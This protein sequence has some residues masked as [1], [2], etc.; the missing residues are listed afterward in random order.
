MTYTTLNYY[1][2]EYRGSDID[3][4]VFETLLKH[5]ERKIDSVTYYRIKK[6]GY[7]TFSDFDKEQIGLATCAQI[8]YFHE[9]GGTTTKAFESVQSVSIG[10]ASISKGSDGQSNS[11]SSSN[12]VSPSVYECLAPTGLLYA[13]IGAK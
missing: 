5:A 12:L 10:R 6:Q 9:H 11:Q 1:R 7:D 4:T 2:H 13:G 8:E 3:E